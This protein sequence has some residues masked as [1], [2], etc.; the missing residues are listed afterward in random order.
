MVAASLCGQALAED[1]TTYHKN[2]QRHG[3]Y[4]VSGLTSA[5]AANMHLDP[6]FDGV[7]TGNVYA[8]PLFVKQAGSA[9]GQ[10]IVATESNVVEALN[11]N[12]GAVVW[13]TQLPAPAPRSALGCGNINP[14][15][16]TGTPAIDP[17]AGAIYL[18]AAVL[19]TQGVVKHMLY[20]LSTST[21]A[22]LPNWP[23]DVQAV[24]NAQGQ[25]FDPTI[26]GQRG[27]VLLVGGNV[28][29]TFG[30]LAGDCGDYHGIVVQV[31]P[32]TP[33][34]TAVWETRAAR[35][36]IWSQ[37]GLSSDGT[38]IFATTGN[39]SAATKWGDGEAIIRLKPGLVH[40]TKK[41]DYFTPADWLTLDDDDLD[42]G[43]TDAMPIS[44]AE[45]GGGAALRVLALGKDGNAYLANRDD[46]GGIGGQLAV[47]KFSG[48]AIV[49]A[50]AVYNTGAQTL[51]AFRNG[52]DLSC[53]GSAVTMLSV[54]AS[55]TTPMT[56]IWCAPL[57]GQGAPII[58]TTDGTSNPL[59][60]I[61]GAQGDNLLHAFDALTGA[62]V[63]AG[64]GEA[65]QMDNLN[66]FVTIMAA[67]RRLYVAS[68]NRIY[69]F[70]FK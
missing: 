5:A 60:W 22:V 38:S 52:A 70:T 36:G 24:L 41:V 17:I 8:Q 7:V 62:T 26:Q 27:G 69:A 40:S 65:N 19:S 48:A 9:V 2:I 34:I 4:V 46:L 13:Q 68:N 12:T 42:L 49:T 59:V 3:A 56:E 43:G 1:V 14:E 58:T 55:M 23:I 28:Y 66:H 37:G 11:A 33:A 15:G 10:V 30:G 47:T 29:F 51:V 64:G 45:P 67:N 44:V 39:T 20:A 18:D 63:F 50:P 25:A 6:G 61:V 16:I 35:G 54:T 32:A 21:G 53:G 31:K 57:N